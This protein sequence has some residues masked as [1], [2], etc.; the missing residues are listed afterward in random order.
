LC[1][2][3][4]GGGVGG[5]VWVCGC[6]GGGFLLGVGGG[7]LWGCGFLV[8]CGFVVGWFVGYEFFYS[9]PVGVF[10][11]LKFGGIF[12]V[13]CGGWVVLVFGC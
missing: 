6:G 3:V 5:G 8:F 2:W 7:F 12:G 4:G 11:Y 13:L 10:F 9:D 1:V